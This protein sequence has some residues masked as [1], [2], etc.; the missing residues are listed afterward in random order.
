MTLLLFRMEKML[1]RQHFENSFAH[2]KEWFTDNNLLAN[3]DK[4]QIRKYDMKFNTLIFQ[5]IH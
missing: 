4:T 5:K 1:P 3:M 2:R